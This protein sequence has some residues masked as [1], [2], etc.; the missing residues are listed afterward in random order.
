MSNLTTSR[1]NEYTQLLEELKDSITKTGDIA[2]R[3]YEQ[4][5]KDGLP[6]DAIRK[7]IELTLEGVIKERQLRKILP[8]E[9]KHTE[10]IRTLEHEEFA[11]LDAAKYPLLDEA[12]NE[13]AQAYEEEFDRLYSKGALNEI[14]KQ[15][16]KE[17][18][19]DTEIRSLIQDN[20]LEKLF[21]YVDMTKE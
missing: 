12:L 3:L 15:G 7:D 10:K 21:T 5:K 1:S 13:L 11:A 16:A 4:G 20:I 14:F 6:N 9:L 2:I 18:F 19:N 17:G 8:L